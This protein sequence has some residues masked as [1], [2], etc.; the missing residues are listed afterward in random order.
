MPRLAPLLALVS[1]ATSLRAEGLIQ[2]TLEGA[3]EAKDGARIEIEVDIA[4]GE[5][6]TSA[7]L[8]ILLAPGTGA[9]A[10]AE[11]LQHRLTAAGA[12][13]FVTRPDP[14]L[15]RPRADLF[16]EHATYVALRLGRGL[17]SRIT[18]CE[19]PPKGLSVH[20]GELAPAETTLS[21]FATTLHPHTET[22]RDA[23]LEFAILADAPAAQV[24]A[25]L[26]KHAISQGWSC[27]RPEDETWQ[28]LKLTDGSMIVGFAVELRG[29][30]DSRL[31][32][33]L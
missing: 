16:I 30:S 9:P 13:S 31:E 14:Q 18:I 8:D 3:L 12:V 22:R 32:V 21:L 24:A 26:L 6:S 27:E 28:P 23:A 33:E 19:G 5:G 2:L 20:P 7:R 1:L 11:L 17:S 15:P 29:E 4:A 25:E 10:L